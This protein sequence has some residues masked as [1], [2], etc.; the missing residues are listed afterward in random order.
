MILNLFKRIFNNKDKVPKIKI[1]TS[2]LDPKEIAIRLKQDPEFVQ[3]L[4]SISKNK[5][6]ILKRIEE[7]ECLNNDTKS[8]K[9]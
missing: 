2:K 1:D 7:L 3:A 6:I 5:E 8:Q 9:S 4:E